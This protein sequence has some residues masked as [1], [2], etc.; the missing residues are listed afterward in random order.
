MEPRADYAKVS[1]GAY[2]ALVELHR[3]L[4]GCG[5]DPA[6]V[7][8]VYLRA[9]QMNGCAFCVDMHQLEAVDLGLS[10]AKL[11]LLE[12][13]RANSAFD[14]QE[15]AALAWCEALTDIQTHAPDDA[16][17]AVLTHFGQKDAVELTFAIASI[18]AWNRIAIGLRTPIPT[19]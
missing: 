4:K 10:E 13:W 16:Y 5:L 2:R 8:L 7:E 19:R 1:P 14:D 6:L 11:A 9:S 12:D 18:N 15:R 17:Q 3:Y